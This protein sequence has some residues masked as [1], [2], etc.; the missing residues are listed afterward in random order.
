MQGAGDPTQA[1][2]DLMEGMRVYMDLEQDDEDLAVA[3]RI[4]AQ[5]QGLLA[6][7]QREA[8]QAMGVGPAAKHLRRLNA[9]M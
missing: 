2:R 4:L 1:L 5:I 8:D 7:Q 9:G 3:T 6:K